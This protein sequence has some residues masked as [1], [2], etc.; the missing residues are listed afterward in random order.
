LA[1]ATTVFVAAPMALITG[2]LQSPA[3]ASKI[4]SGRGI[5]NRQVSRTVHFLVLVYFVGFIAVHV[6]MVFVTGALV[7][8]NHI[9]R[10]VNAGGWGGARLFGIG[11]GI[12]IVLWVVATP[13]TLNF[14]RVVQ[15]VGRGLVGWMMAG[16]ERWRPSAEYSEKDISPFF[17]VN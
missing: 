11:I 14:P 1:Y 16:M 2:L 13:F 6:M 15:K 9:T 8:F 4:S 3:V 7:N 10:G 5:L 17:W 12:V